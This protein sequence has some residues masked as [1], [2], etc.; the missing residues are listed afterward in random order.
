MERQKG[1]TEFDEYAKCKAKT[2][3]RGKDEDKSGM[4]THLRVEVVVRLM[5]RRR[6]MTDKEEGSRRGRVEEMR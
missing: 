5:N 1:S 4:K 3:G 2:H 6:E